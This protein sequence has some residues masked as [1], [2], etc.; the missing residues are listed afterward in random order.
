LND[1]IQRLRREGLNLIVLREGRTLF[2]SSE[3]GM[4]PLYEAINNLGLFVL[5]GS[6]IVDKIVG[7]AAALILSYFKAKEV[8]CATLSVRGREVLDRYG[9]KHYSEGLTEEIMNKLGTGICPFEKA[10]LDVDDPEEGYERVYA[11]LKSLGL[12]RNR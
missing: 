2:T 12:L 8:H 5:E 11:R 1:Y 7:K 10:V 3:E 4:R 9:I 6:V